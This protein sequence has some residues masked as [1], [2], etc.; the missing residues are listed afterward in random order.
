MKRL[1]FGILILIFALVA[2]SGEQEESVQ[3]SN[4][5]VVA[6]IQANL[7]LPSDTGSFWME[8]TN[9]TGK[10][11]TLLGAEFDGCGAIELHDMTMENDIMVMRP[12]EGGKILIPAGE[13]VELKRGGLHIMCI[14]KDAPLEPGTMVD[15]TLQFANEGD[16][17]VKG[18]VVAPGDMPMGGMDHENT[19]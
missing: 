6:H 15:F 13:T 12:V 2:C 1:W 11:D 4:E 17:S 16:V 14:N 3:T 19:E 10:D 8:I 18:M 9:N 7:A 5:L